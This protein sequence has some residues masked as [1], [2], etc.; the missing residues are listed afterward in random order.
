MALDFSIAENRVGTEIVA[1]AM[2]VHSALGPGLLEST[3][4]RCLAYEIE[5]RA[6]RARNQVSIPLRYGDLFIENAYKID[7]LVNDLV[8]VEIKSLEGV[9]SVHRAQLMSYLRLGGFRL[10]FLLNFNVAHLRD[11]IVRR[12]NGL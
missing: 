2:A 8:V 5:K 4:E 9:T 1:A 6:L 7:L 10:G 12:A 11:G 3:Y